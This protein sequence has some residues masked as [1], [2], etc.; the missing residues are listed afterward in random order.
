MI[1]G[2]AVLTLP[3][4]STCLKRFSRQVGVTMRSHGDNVVW[5]PAGSNLSFDRKRNFAP[6]K[7]SRG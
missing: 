6:V 2:Y 5:T 4:I 3:V 7:D 1:S